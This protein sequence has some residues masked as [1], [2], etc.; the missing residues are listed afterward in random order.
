M[1]DILCGYQD[2]EATLMAYIY[3]EITPDERDAF[4][5]HLTTCA[6]CRVE[7]NA[8]GGVRAQLARWAPPDY[9]QSAQ[10]ATSGSLFPVGRPIVPIAPKLVERDVE[11]ESRSARPSGPAGDVRRNWRDIPAWAQVAAAVLVLGASAGMANLNVHYDAQ[12]GL[13]IRTGWSQ[14]SQGSE[15]SASAQDSHGSRGSQTADLN[16]ASRAELTAL[17]QQLRSEIQAASTSA[18]VASKPAGDGEAVPRRVKALLDESERR[19]EREMALRIAEVIRDVNAQRTS[20]LR[21]IDQNID[22]GRV[23]VLRNRQML[24]Y[25]VQRVS[26]PQ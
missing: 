2:R 26:R 23:E 8:L 20:D 16:F 6:R 13:N 24:D 11:A 4:D 17:E 18:A 1:S 9:R 19:H 7:L 14:G 12:N 22:Q 5:T 10:S 3:D 21:K 25:Y 15:G